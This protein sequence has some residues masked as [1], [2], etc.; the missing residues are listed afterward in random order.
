VSDTLIGYQKDHETR[1][2]Q[3][4]TV[5]DLGETVRLSEARGDEYRSL[6]QLYKALG[7]GWQQ[8]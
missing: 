3:E 8:Y 2:R 7:G 4:Q 1:L 6:V 5:A